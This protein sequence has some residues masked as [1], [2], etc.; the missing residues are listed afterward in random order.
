MLSI[1]SGLN[2]SNKRN[3]QITLVSVLITHPQKPRYGK[4]VTRLS[5]IH[6]LEAKIENNINGTIVKV[7]PFK[8]K[9]EDKGTA[10]TVDIR[11]IMEQNNYT[12]MFLKIIGDKLNRV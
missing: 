11:I 8:T 2:S 4:L 6:Y 3:I 10:S 7:S 12:N 9:P 5:S 1:G